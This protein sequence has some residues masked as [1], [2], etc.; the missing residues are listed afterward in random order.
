MAGKRE[1]CVTQSEVVTRIISSCIFFPKHLQGER[2]SGAN[3]P[4][5]TKQ[6]I[7][8]KATSVTSKRGL[9][10]GAPLQPS[11]DLEDFFFSLIFHLQPDLY[12][13]QQNEF[14][15]MGGWKEDF[16]T[17]S[18]SSGH[19]KPNIDPTGGIPIP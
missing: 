16:L 17:G 15:T 1:E 4:C 14:G 8:A 5:A 11:L 3:G 7:A 12:L 2:D 13:I 19:C 9:L 18:L 10:N 6:I